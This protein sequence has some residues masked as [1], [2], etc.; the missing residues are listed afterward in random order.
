MKILICGS[1]QQ[2][3]ELD[4]SA[5]E[6]R[7][8]IFTVSALSDFD[9]LS[10]LDACFLLNAE[11]MDYTT[12]PDRVPVF[13][14]EVVRT[15]KEMNASGNIIRINGWPGFLQRKVWEASGIISQNAIEAARIIG[16][17]LIQVNDEPGLVAA[18]VISMIINEAF[19]VLHEKVSTK[20]EIDKAMRLATNYPFGPF[21]W[22]EKIGLKKVHDLLTVLSKEDTKY[23]P[24]F[25]LAN[26]TA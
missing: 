7:K 17:E 3:D 26:L 24:S 15:N 1:G 11:N 22:G 9:R 13:V 10:E 21:T 20:E 12:L 16:K 8:N 23:L 5:P 4:L 2:L 6:D 25:D 18:T 19:F 14:N